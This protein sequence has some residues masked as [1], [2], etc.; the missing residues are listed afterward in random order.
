MPITSPCEKHSGRLQGIGS[1]IKAGSG[2][3]DTLLILWLAKTSC[4]RVSRAYIC[5][6]C[7]RACNLRGVI[8]FSP[9]EHPH[10]TERIPR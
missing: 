3:T 6:N 4:V 10:K 2:Y 7:L 9:I 1:R 8:F 5:E